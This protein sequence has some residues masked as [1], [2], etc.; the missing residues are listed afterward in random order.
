MSRAVLPLHQPFPDTARKSSLCC[1]LFPRHLLGV[2]VARVMN[3]VTGSERTGSDFRQ[4]WFECQL[5]HSVQV[6]SVYAFVNEGN[7]NGNFI[8]MVWR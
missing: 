2:P 5:C 3:G 4:T 1:F 7:N 8:G 6:G